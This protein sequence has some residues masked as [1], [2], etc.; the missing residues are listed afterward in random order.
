MR[1]CSDW[2]VT[3]PAARTSQTVN[4]ERT[5]PFDLRKGAQRTKLNILLSPFSPRFVSDL[6]LF[7][8]ASFSL[9]SGNYALTLQHFY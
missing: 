4:E 3:R 8:S 7:S 5:C 9:S 1:S 2:R 6:F